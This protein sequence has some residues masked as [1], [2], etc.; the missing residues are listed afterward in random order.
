V[1]TKPEDVQKG[2]LETYHDNETAGHPGATRTYHQTAQGY[3]WPGLRKYVRAYV[4]GCG[5]CQQNKINTHPNRPTL[6]P[7]SPPENPDP[8]KVISVDLITKLP[9]SKGNDTIL[10]ITDQGST[11][12]VILI[13]CNETMGTEQLAH[14]YKKHA[15]PFIGIPSK[16]ISDRDVWFTS[17]LFQEICRQ[18]G[19][20]QNI[21][22]AYH[23]ETDGQSERTN[24]TVETALRIFGNYR[25]DDWSDW[26]PIVQYQLNSHVSNTTGFT[27]FE[28][29]MGYIPR[30]HQPD[31][32]SGMP[33]VQKRKEQLF[34]VRKQA[35]ESMTRAQ[36]SWAKKKRPHKPY[37]KGEKVWLKGKN[38]RTS[39]P[40]TKLRPRRFGPFKVTEV[41][42]PTTYRLDLP[43]M[44]KIH[45]AFHG[46]LLSPYQETEEHGVNF[47][48]P[49]PE[50]IEGEPE[51]EVE[52]ILGSRR[53]GQGRKLQFLVQWKGYAPAHNSW[54]P[55]T[56][57]HAPELI[58]EFYQEEPMAIKRVAMGTI[59]TANEPHPMAS[60]LLTPP[61]LPSL[62]YP[63]DSESD[64]FYL[65]KP[66]QDDSFEFIGA[67][68]PHSRNRVTNGNG[69]DDTP[70][71]RSMPSP[72]VPAG[73]PQLIVCD[74]D[75]GRTIEDPDLPISL[76]ATYP[77]PLWFRL[78]DVP[79]HPSFQI[80]IGDQ[81]VTL[82]YLRYQECNGEPF[83]LGT[84]G[85]GRPVHF[86]PV[87]LNPSSNVE[88]S[89]YDDRDLDILTQDPTFNT[90]LAQA[91][92]QVGDP[93]VTA[94]VAR[95]RALNAQLTVITSRATLFDKMCKALVDIQKERQALDKE[96]L[97]HLEGSKQRLIAGRAKSRVAKQVD[98]LNQN[99]ELRAKYYRVREHQR[100]YL[101]RQHSTIVNDDKLLKTTE[102]QE[103][104]DEYS[105]FKARMVEK[106]QK[107]HTCHWC[108]IRG[109]FNKACPVPHSRCH[110]VCNVPIEHAYYSPKACPWP[111]KRTRKPG[112]PRKF[113]SPPPVASLNDSNM[114]DV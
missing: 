23:P 55:Q 93:S 71:P 27:P 52:K 47:T 39:H 42:G 59:P 100:P 3:W 70:L 67:T 9:D 103:K 25:Q 87:I 13:P 84:E 33:E 34:E 88:G 43:S 2:L 104:M 58:K 37:A 21:S 62:R 89:L 107:R 22:S 30:A 5:I 108:N 97:H 57:I 72:E 114:M 35:Q 78:A 53:H 74:E 29:W 112:R 99:G 106:R 44:W 81:I 110:N 101:A 17:R 86:R 12:A 63:S 31:R 19:V 32:V 7:I 28:I 6:H 38:L 40:T 54:E 69:T 92:N 82:P 65:Y 66:P 49:P 83:L 20:R 95:F 45:N 10:T 26:L 105:L 60:H 91:L 98:I 109:H 8:F 1:I 90:D 61:S 111:P 24:Q 73:T 79:G 4:K 85:K 18:L 15:F 48:E 51:Y 46:A 41:L 75:S 102:A 56:N 64:D 77:G 16:L 50:L 76:D 36:Q 14:L 94:E 11:K 113:Y 80:I 68:R 96:F